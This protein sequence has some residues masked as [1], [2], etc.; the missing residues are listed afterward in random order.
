MKKPLPKIPVPQPSQESIMREIRG[1]QLELDTLK[2][3]ILSETNM[4]VLEEDLVREFQHLKAEVKESVKKNTHTVERM[5]AEVKFLKEDVGR[6]M[7]LEE[8]MNRLNM[9]SLTR[10]MESLK[11]KSHWLEGKIGTF[12]L[13]PVIEKISDMED[14]IKIMKASQPLILE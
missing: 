2:K 5:E 4:R 14:K 13:D 6:V 9:K 8:E 12:D 1:M 10:D 11:A 7:G 3:S